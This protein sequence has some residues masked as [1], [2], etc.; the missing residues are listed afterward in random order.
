MN[1]ITV[2]VNGIEYNLKGEEQEEYLHKIAGFVDKKIK[3]IMDNN[4]K[5]GT[6]SAAVLVAMNA[7]DDMFK[8]IEEYKKLKDTVEL[9]QKD[10][11]ELKEQYQSLKNQFKHIED[12]NSELQLKIKG[13]QNNSILKQKEDEL[14]SLME[15]SKESLSQCKDLKSE[16]KELKFVVQSYKYKIMD[17]EHKLL[18][19]QLE[20]AKEKKRN[21]PCIV[22]E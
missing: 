13:F 9:I 3:F 10:N 14:E 5:L 20:L 15:S 6:S 2:K 17:L 8:S 7:A 21:H 16:N 22:K 12:Y 1:I 18:E 11:K 19:Y 4:N